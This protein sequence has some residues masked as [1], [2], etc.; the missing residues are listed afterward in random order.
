MIG[1]LLRN[2]KLIAVAS[3]AASLWGAHVI[4]KRSSYEA[5]KKDALSDVH[6]AANK[7]GALADKASDEVRRCY[8]SGK[9]W[10]REAGKCAQ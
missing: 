7:S 2:W 9:T 3:L 4:S 8:A 10:N 5:G 6:S 1:W